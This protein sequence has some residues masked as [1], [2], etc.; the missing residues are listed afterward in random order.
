MENNGHFGGNIQPAV[1]LE[2]HD[3]LN[4]AKQ[5]V[6][7]SPMTIN[8]VVNTFGGNVTLNPSPNY[9]GLVSINGNVVASNTPLSGKTLNTYSTRV[10]S[11]TTTTPAS[12]TIYVSSIVITTEIVGTTSTITIQDKQGTPR[13][14][15][16]GF[17]TTSLNTTPTVLDFETPIIMTSG[18]DIIT[19]GVA[20][21]TVD[22]WVNYY[23]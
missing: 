21:A 14:L 20:A 23:Q 16:N 15:V 6:L 10:T 1:D 9:I 19:A 3:H 4:K 8:A 18:M 22:I 11:N 13:I 17:V 12:A 2:E 5:V 7:V